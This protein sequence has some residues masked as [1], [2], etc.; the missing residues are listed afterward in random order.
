VAREADRALATGEALSSAV[1]AAALEASG[2][3]ARSLSGAE[4]GILAAGPFGSAAIL[5]VETARIERLLAAAVV[6]VVAGFQG[7]RDDGETVTLG[8]GSSDTTAVA[9]AAALGAECHIVTDV[10]AV[11]DRDPRVDPDARALPSLTADELVALAESGAKV[12]QAGAAHLARD[13]GVPLHIYSFRAPLSGQGGTV[14]RAPTDARARRTAV[15]P[16][17]VHDTGDVQRLDPDS[18]AR[19]VDADL[20]STAG[21]VFLGSAETPSR[22]VRA[23]SG[24]GGRT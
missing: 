24:A 19:S 6:P 18:P 8:R 16:T 3:R 11:F 10:A 9:L 14:V 2:V 13:A 5:R 1:L 20:R 7:G 22:A 4:G 17:L 21:A 12:V 15:G 23:L